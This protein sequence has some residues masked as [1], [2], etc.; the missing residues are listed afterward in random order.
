VTDAAKDV[1]TTLAILAVQGTVLAVLAFAIT[2]RMRPAWQAAV[3]LVVVAKFALPWA[4]ALPWSLADLFATVNADP[5]APIILW[6]ATTLAPIEPVQTASVFW[7]VLAAAWAAGTAIVLS[8]ALVATVR[9]ARAATRAIAAPPEAHQLLAELCGDRHDNLVG[10]FR[11][12]RIGWMRRVRLVIGDAAIGPHVVGVLR[13]IIVVPPA[14]FEQPALLRA[15]LLHELAHVRRF[16]AIGRLVELIAVALFWW[17]PVTRLASR[18]L[19]AAREAAC[20]AWALSASGVSAP[21]YARLLLEMSRLGVAAAPALSSPRALEERVTRVLGPPVR[22]RLSRLHWL[23]L[24]AWIAL[25]L[26]GA[27]ASEAAEPRIVCVYTL[28]IAEAL[29]AAH[30]E[31]DVDGDG[32]VSHD[33]A[34]EFQAEVAR[35]VVDSAQVSRLD[36]ATAE[37]LA[38]PLCCNCSAGEGLSGAPSAEATCQAQE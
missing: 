33:E 32:A 22:P 28:Q 29:R 31:A 3:W 18:R 21:A 34:C 17:L 26:G 37:L 10:T 24:A 19:E 35:R 20:D 27:R 4:P 16:D 5:E 8:R 2:R 25:A 7:L 12:S 23:A 13:P 11:A 14:L 9:T 30:P 36:E 6:S 1:V 38:E 15:A